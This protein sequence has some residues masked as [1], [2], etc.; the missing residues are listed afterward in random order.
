MRRGR[1]ALLL[2]IQSTDIVRL[3]GASV[4]DVSRVPAS[5][6]VER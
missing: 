4:A 5:E 1:P 3:T 6:S 2:K